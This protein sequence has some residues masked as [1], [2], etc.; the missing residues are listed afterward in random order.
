MLRRWLEKLA[1]SNTLYYPGCVTR[2]A[3]PEIQQRYEFLLRRAGVDFIVLPGETLC[4][5]S[6]VKRAGYLADFEDLK[7]KNLAIFARFSVRKIITN[8]PGCYH[9]LKHDY[10][11]EAYH[12]AQI[13]R[14]E[15][16]PGQ[17]GS[18]ATSSLTYHDPCHLGRWSGIYDEPRRL[19][20]E[21]GWDIAELPDNREHSLCCGAGGG[22]KSN[23]P[24]LADAVARQRL[25]LVENGRLCTACPLCYAHFKENADQVEVLEFSEALATEW[26]AQ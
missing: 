13:L 5:G 3:L 23:F 11:L 14:P 20:S 1:G 22:V 12:I 16:L 19:L 4:C 2:Y 25:A 26:E 7:A 9:T 8:C 10:G 6:P 15:R 18:D 24:E 21:A 17:K